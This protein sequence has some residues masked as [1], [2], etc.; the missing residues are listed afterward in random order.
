MGGIMDVLLTHVAGVDVHKDILV[1]TTLIGAPGEKP[2][3]Q[4]FECRTFTEDL[5]KMG[6]TLVSMGVLDVVM[7]STGIYWKP[8]F[9]VWRPLGIRVTIGNAYHIKNVPGR[10]TDLKDSHWLAQLHRNGLIRAS[11]IPEQEFQEARALTRQRKNLVEDLT[12]VKNRV[13]KVLEDGNVKLASVASDLFGVGGLAVLRRIAE[14]EKKPLKLAMAIETSLN[15]KREELRKALTNT[16]T[17]NHCFLINQLLGQY[18]Y[19]MNMIADLDREIDSRMEKHYDIIERLV[20]IPG[21]RVDTA[22]A[23]V[24][25]ACTAMENFKDERMFSA[26]AGVAPGNNESAQKKRDAEPEK[27]TQR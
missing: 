20:E 11:Y 26:W 3:V 16:L 22:E 8:V 14:G 12:R 9:N 27:E 19:I 5:E 25:E 10:K 4:H 17:K 7:E 18:D 21:I 6:M 2:K 24:A 13:A 23:I 15:K 1:I